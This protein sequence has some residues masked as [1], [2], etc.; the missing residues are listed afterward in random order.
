MDLKPKALLWLIGPMER[1]LVKMVLSRVGYQAI[2]CADLD[3]LQKNISELSPSLVILD[4]VLP[5]QNGLDITKKIKEGCGS[6]SP[7]IILVSALAFPEVVVQ[8]RQAGADDFIAKPID[9]DL[10]FNRI[11]LLAKKTLSASLNKT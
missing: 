6:L 3:D 11:S 1:D 5:G 8:A 4:I 7:A 2:A 9:S 10:L